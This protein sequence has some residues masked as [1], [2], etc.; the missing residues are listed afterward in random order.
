[1]RIGNENTEYKI[2]PELDKNYPDWANGDPG[3]PD[4]IDSLRDSHLFFQAC[5]R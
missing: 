5:F 1:M 2:D 4:R 3:A